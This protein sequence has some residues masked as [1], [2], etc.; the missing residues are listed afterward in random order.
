MKKEKYM[1]LKLL[2]LLFICH[3][4]ADYTPLSTSWMLN[5]KRIG[6]PLFPILVHAS[7]HAFL[8]GAVLCWFVGVTTILAYLFMIELLTHFLIDVCKGR[9]N[10]I[11]PSLQ[12]PAN[13]WHW[14][15]FGFDQLLHSIVIIYIVYFIT[16]TP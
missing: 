5:A 1:E 7:V 3:W 13:K 2:I 9:V 6:K 15:V 11:F 4:L 10:V 8:M 16:Q 12:S 14:V